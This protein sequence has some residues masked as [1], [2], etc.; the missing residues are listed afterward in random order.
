[1]EAAQEALDSAEQALEG[2]EGC[3]GGAGFPVAT[4]ACLAL[5]AS[6]LLLQEAPPPSQGSLVVW[7]QCAPPPAVVPAA[8]AQGTAVDASS[9]V[10]ISD[11]VGS[12]SSKSVYSE[13]LES[14]QA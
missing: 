7:R 4:A 8:G 2:G 3:G 13:D 10:F 12:L 1:M 11:I 14:N 9:R 5:R 6:L